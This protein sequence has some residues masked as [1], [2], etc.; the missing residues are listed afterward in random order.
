[1][2]ILRAAHLGMCFGVRDAIALAFE[3]AGMG[4]R[5]RPKLLAY[6]GL[7]TADGFFRS[8]KGE[9]DS[10]GEAIWT[11]VNHVRLGG[12]YFDGLAWQ[13][14]YASCVSPTGGWTQ[15]CVDFARASCTQMMTPHSECDNSGEERW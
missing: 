2:R 15:R 12:A 11:V 13:F 4:A 14:P 10:N 7:Q 5:V 9:W 3:H 1:M 8:Q 6:P